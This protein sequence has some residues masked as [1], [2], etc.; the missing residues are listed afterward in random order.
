MKKLKK[1]HQSDSQVPKY[2]LTQEKNDA[3]CL[4]TGGAGGIG[5]EFAKLFLQENYKIILVDISREKLEEA[6]LRLTKDCAAEVLTLK[7]NLCKRGVA[8]EI[9]KKLNEENIR[10]EV[11]VNNAG[12]GVFGEFHETDLRKQSDLIELS[13][14]TNTQLTHLFLKDMVER[15]HGKILNIA[16]IAAFQ[17]GPLMAVY[18]AS[19]AY[20]V[21]FSRAIANELKNTNVT[22]TV[23]CPGMTRTGFQMANGN[24]NP[25]YGLLSTTAQKV[26]NYGFQALMKGKAVAIPR[27]YNR[28]ISNIHR[29]LPLETATRLSRFLQEKNRVK[30]IEAGIRDNSSENH[31]LT[32]G[33]E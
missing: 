29:F 12:F 8:W 22:V 17:P 2:Q 5:F 13:I 3:Y 31:M 18:Y 19:K 10:V 9:Y 23:L 25:K 7:Y 14:N 21:S 20:L 11:L 26:A 6:K 30:I 16:S 28:I 32:A 33:I 4:I 24:P 1:P 27:F 15:N